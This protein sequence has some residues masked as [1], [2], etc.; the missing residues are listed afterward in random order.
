MVYNILFESAG[1]LEIPTMVINFCGKWLLTDR[2]TESVESVAG[3][4][5]IYVGV[6]AHLSVLCL[7][8]WQQ[9]HSFI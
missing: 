2:V 9:D 4:D 1:D 3:L 6:N 5:G 8:M 7:G